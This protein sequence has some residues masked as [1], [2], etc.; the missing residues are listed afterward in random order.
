LEE[1]QQALGEVVAAILVSGSIPIVLGGGHETAYGHYLGYV[2]ASLS[3]GT[4]NLDAHLDVRPWTDGR[5]HSGSPFRQALDPP[6][7]PLP[8]RCYVCLGAQPPAVSREHISYVQ[9]K[10]CTVRWQP[11]FKG[12]LNRFFTEECRRLVGEAGRVYFT[13]DAD[14]VQ[15]AD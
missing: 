8:G 10:G 11:E 13:L 14:V 9:Q 2:A 3:V 7:R 1:S 5:G 4:L 12:D 6:E 15:T